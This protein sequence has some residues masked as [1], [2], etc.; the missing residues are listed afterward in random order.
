[1]AV[2]ESFKIASSALLTQVLAQQ[3]DLEVCDFEILTDRP[4]PHIKAA[5][6][7]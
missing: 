7:V 5:V 3:A 4:H 6:A 2:T 1:M